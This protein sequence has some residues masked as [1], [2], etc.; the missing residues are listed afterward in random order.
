MVLD[1]W[2]CLGLPKTGKHDLWDCRS[3][4]RWIK[5][6]EQ[7]LM[8]WRRFGGWKSAP[9]N[10]MCTRLW[11]GRMSIY[12]PENRGHAG[13]WYVHTSRRHDVDCNERVGR[14]T[15][16]SNSCL[17]RLFYVALIP[18]IRWCLDGGQVQNS[19]PTTPTM[20]LTKNTQSCQLKTRKWKTMAAKTFALQGYAGPLVFTLK[21]G[22]KSQCNLALWYFDD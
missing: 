11:L 17:P 16:D 22:S 12:T 6:T 15:Q 18:Q 2:G 13:V 5:R 21:F 14:P 20:L 7:R 19:P 9:N 4:F 8:A 10:S 1:P 3:R